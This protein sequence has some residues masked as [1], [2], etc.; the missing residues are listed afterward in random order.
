MWQLGNFL[1]TVL[2]LCTI[3]AMTNQLRILDPYYSCLPCFDLLVFT[4]NGHNPG[5]LLRGTIIMVYFK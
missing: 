2:I 3:E 4:V 1:S 5:L